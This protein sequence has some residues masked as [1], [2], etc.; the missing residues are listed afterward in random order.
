MN[1]APKADSKRLMNTK[2]FTVGCFFLALATPAPA[3]AATPNAVPVAAPEGAQYVHD[4]VKVARTMLESEDVYDRILAAGALAETGDK[5]ALELLQKYLGAED[6][7][8]KRS[9][10]D[11]LLSGTHP[12][13][14]EL[15]MR[16]AANDSMALNLMVESLAANPRDD[17]EDLLIGALDSSKANMRKNALQALSNT[18]TPRVTAAVHK[19][20]D[21]PAEIPTVRGYGY[22]ALAATGHGGDVMK[23]I[24]E[25]AKSG[26]TSDEREVA[27]VAL[28]RIN[29][30]ES[31]KA[32]AE[33]S[34]ADD[35]RVKI[36][37]IASSAGLRNDDALA[38]F[39]KTVAYGKP[40]EATIMAGAVRRLPPEIA[41]DITKTLISCC[42]LKTDIATRLLESWGWVA[43][44]PAF[45]YTWGLQN[46]DMEVRL[47]T[48]W[49]VGHRKDTAWLAKIA[50]Y[51]NDE[52]PALRAMAAWAIIHTA[53]DGYVGGVET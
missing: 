31:Q 6:L 15:L 38:Q 32:L 35:G 11:T 27:A 23:G 44:D 26:E 24:L 33:L 43:S 21:N 17:L 46:T 28:G 18:D 29:T 20:I 22:Y 51:L 12:S 37:A 14:I 3:P 42:H 10:I 41:R 8:I 13:T 25:L 39:V 4:A 53:G 34:K 52:I 19:V 7:V 49:L 36:A 40:L 48:L 45:V 50:P 16:S 30:K 1:A 5:A 2:I 47:Q 9:A